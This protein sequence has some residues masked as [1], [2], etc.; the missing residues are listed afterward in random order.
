MDLAKA[1]LGLKVQR[2]A[3]GIGGEAKSV[4][5]RGKSATYYSPP[6]PHTRLARHLT[7]DL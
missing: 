3:L 4:G 1:K 5:K 2:S 6:T 7:P